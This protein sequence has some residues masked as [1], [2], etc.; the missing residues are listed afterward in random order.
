MNLVY[1]T[2]LY[3]SVVFESPVQTSILSR[4]LPDVYSATPAPQPFR[5]TT[6]LILLL[7]QLV[8]AF[9][10]QQTYLEQVRYIVPNLLERPSDV[11]LGLSHPDAFKHL[12]PSSR[13]IAS[14]DVRVTTVLQDLPRIA[15]HALVSRL[16]L[17]ARD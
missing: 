4:L 16:R 2:S 5:L 8:I 9:P 14:S 12:L 17:K 13:P 6:I 15:V 7:H 11:Y 10:S 1:E 3:L